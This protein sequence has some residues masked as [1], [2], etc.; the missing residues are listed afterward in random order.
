L[1]LL[2]LLAGLAT[3]LGL[4]GCDYPEQGFFLLNA[5]DGGGHIVGKH[6]FEIEELVDD[7]DLTYGFAVHLYD[8]ARKRVLDLPFANSTDFSRRAWLFTLAG[9]DYGQGDLALDFT[10]DDHLSFVGA[11]R[12]APD[13]RAYPLAGEVESTDEDKPSAVTFDS[14]LPS[15]VPGSDGPGGPIVGFLVQE[16]SEAEAAKFLGAKP[17]TFKHVKGMEPQGLDPELGRTV[18]TASGGQTNAAA[19]Q[20]VPAGTDSA[21]PAS[22]PHPAPPPPL[23]GK[24]RP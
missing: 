1:T 9:S 13:R 7:T 19:G 4:T 10:H 8:P 24:G 21:T 14:P 11:W 22:R 23:G 12:A 17:K 20:V 16:V 2:A 6:L 15:G 18:A 5:V 3:I